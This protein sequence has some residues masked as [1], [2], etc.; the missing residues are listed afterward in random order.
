MAQVYEKVFDFGIG[1][2]PLVK[3]VG[4]VQD[5]DGQF[6]G[7][8]RAG[9]FFRMTP[10]GTVT[11]LGEFNNGYGMTG[12]VRAS[13]GN[14]YSTRFG[15]DIEGQKGAV[16]K[17]T[18]FGTLTQIAGFAGNGPASLGE[19]PA[20]SLLQVGSYFFG[21]TVYGGT[22]NHGTIFKVS[23][24]GE[25]ST[26]IEFT[27]G[28]SN[29]RGSRP[30]AALVLGDDGNLYGTTT[31]G[32]IHGGGTVFK[33]TPSG[34][35]T[36][37]VDFTH[38]EGPNR[39]SW[40]GV[41][42]SGSDGNFY[43]LT[44]YG[45]TLGGGTV[46]K[47]TPSGVLT[48]LA[49][50]SAEYDPD[51]ETGYD[52]FPDSL[53]QGSD[54]NF[55]GTTETDKTEAG[56]DFVGGTVFKMTA[57]GDLTTLVEFDDSEVTDR[58]DIHLRNSSLIQGNDG[59][60]YGTTAFGGA[61]GDGAVFRVSASGLFSHLVEFDGP[62]QTRSPSFP[63]AL[64]QGDDGRFFGTTAYG[65][66]GNRGTVFELKT[67]GELTTFVEF[68]GNGPVNNGSTP[69]AALVQGQDGN[70]YGST[71]YGGASEELDMPAS[72][73]GTIFRMTPSGVLTTLVSFTGSE[74]TNRGSA[75]AADLLRDN[76]G[77]FIG[78]TQSGGA[79]GRG[80]VFKMSPSG[81]MTTLVDFSFTSP[82]RGRVPNAL[83]SGNDGNFY[84]TTREGG[85]GGIGNGTVF[86]MTPGGILTTLVEFTWN[87]PPYKGSQPNALV[88]GNDGNFYGTT[89]GG[90]IG[91]DGDSR[92]GYGTVF[93]MT[94]EGALTTLVEFTL[95]GPLNKGSQPTK[96]VLA[97]DGHFYGTTTYGGFGS[98]EAA[99]IPGARFTGYGTLFKMTHSGELTTIW[100][101][102]GAEGN[103][104]VDLVAG[105]DGN[106]YGTTGGPHGTIY[107]LVFP[108]V[109][110]IGLTQ[111]TP[112]LGGHVQVNARVNARGTFTQAS[113][114]Y[115][116]D[117]VSFP[118]TIPLSPNLN[119]FQTQTAGTS[120]EGLNPGATYFY[121]VRAQSIRGT[122]VSPV[123]SF[124]TLAAPLSTVTPATDLA[125]ASARLNGTVNAR[126]YDATVRFEWGTDGN[127]FPNSVAATPGTVTGNSDVSVSVP[128]AGLTKGTT[129]YFRVVATNAGGTT[130]SGTQS[131]RTL[132]EPAATI[133][134]NFALT[135]TSV[136]V[137]GSVNAQGSDSSVVFEYGTDGV[138]F[139]NSVAA[140]PGT[141]SGDAG[142]PVSAVLTTLSQGVTYHYRIRATSA[143]GVGTSASA[144]FSMNV[145]SGFAQVFPNAPPESEGFLTVNLS[146]GGILHG[147]RFVGE[148]QWRSSGLPVAGLTTSNREIEF[149]PVPGYVQPEPEP[150]S[151]LSGEA[152][153][154]AFE[155]IS[156]GS[157]GSGNILVTL[158]PSTLAEA[159]W[160]LLGETDAQ[161]RNSDTAL[162]GLPPGNYLIECKP[163]AGRATPPNVN[164]SVI[165]GQTTAA[166]IT[167][168]LPD[169]ATG[170]PP[171]VLSFE[172]VSVDTTRPY[173]HVGQFRSQVGSS[174]GFVVKPRVVATAAH[175]VWDDGR[176]V[177]NG[178]GGSTLA[179][180]Q[181]VQWLF[182]RYRGVHEPTPVIPRG[183]YT[184]DGY[185]AQ[186]V[187][188]NSPGDS[189]PA[190]QHLDVAAVY[191]STNA[192][193]GGYSGFLASDLAQNEFLLSSAN[194]MLVGYPMDGIST[195]SQGRMHATSP[196]NVV[197][198]SSFGRTFT[199]TGIRS[200]GGNSGGPLCV[201]FEGG[202][203]Y[204]TAIYLGGDNQTVVRAIDSEVVD[205][206]N[207]A[208]ISSNGG[209]NNTGG[210]ITHTSISGTTS[211]STG[212]VQI[213]IEPEAARNAGAGWRL[214]DSGSYRANGA[215]RSSVTP[216]SYTLNMIAVAGFDTPTSPTI[217]VSGGQLTAVT[218]TYAPLMNPQESW[219]QTH[220]STT[221]NTGNAADTFD[222]DGD[223]FTN[224]QEYAAGTN[225]TLS[226]DFF[227]V[228]DSQRTA[229]TFTLS[230]AG[231]AGRTYTLQRSVNLSSWTAVGSPQGPLVS[232]GAVTLQDAAMPN[233]AAFYRI[234]VTG[235]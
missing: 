45:S 20:A 155:Y 73:H 51:E 85:I 16:F 108:G 131:F 109:P 226:G 159:Q 158:K 200:S 8:T 99:A 91:T 137:E 221:A 169:A 227:K 61:A 103:P 57:S 176:V 234:V 145:L 165:N 150:V 156:G 30:V 173:A 128:V 46:F 178:S 121:R 32:G 197:F 119:G 104:Y 153:V 12:L 59:A 134:G 37:L 210:G 15:E 89:T 213:L 157:T 215:V 41:L 124:S 2:N 139:P 98:N 171:A 26:V 74:G 36:T 166:T 161:W 148:Q 68:A 7:I 175:V 115:G 19:H 127:T 207:R 79:Y 66:L 24:N 219:R 95:N 44:R 76:D 64:T 202:A 105:A 120:V 135:T 177:D 56:G 172:S 191:F 132:T 160:R 180:V 209:D 18:P 62:A 184:F 136:R 217:T 113:L 55:Y 4:L 162:N 33:M 90:G 235:P 187:I 71:V 140:T 67:T 83:I 141:V 152:S 218:Y 72:G 181:G 229:S 201:Q 225:P 203:Y 117:G 96:L 118:F 130:V 230:T 206:F 78:A 164:V 69:I 205:L 84:G 192:G 42:V 82:N 97:G 222:F 179:A 183:F 188:D 182:Q 100:E 87:V 60:F 10:G 126:N 110:L 31:Q 198:S 17:M 129:Y 163:V 125:P 40:P 27:G 107:R 50:F 65:G 193:R 102:S 28:E 101:F 204:P 154:Y 106:L 35:L 194:K 123:G 11:N 143:G 23:L 6:Y 5:N 52:T 233:D 211:S 146:T 147:W 14:L 174:S 77:N 92:S 114:E 43:G 228:T 189:S 29:N 190:S 47:M 170:T 212:S 116:N 49:E 142:T 220:F 34:T 196:S 75:P 63:N 111:A 38:D 232:D 81:G 9:T 1:R 39:G 48:T 216:G 70:Y 223:G 133:G 58:D 168:F 22:F 151:I 195:T 54:G 21:T 208:E 186:R 167:Y 231:K 13:D 214:G 94:P 185:A 80:T 88:L 25:L 86:R 112:A 149:R 224:A 122:A 3:P 53:I 199:T 93:R 138:S 144:S